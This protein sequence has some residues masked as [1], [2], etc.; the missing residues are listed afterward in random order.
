MKL[1]SRN[2]FLSILFIVSLNNFSRAQ[3]IRFAV[4]VIVSPDVPKT[5]SL[6]M[7]GNQRAFGNWFDF[8]KGKM[9]KQDDTTWTFTG[10]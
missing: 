8:S 10:Q 7:M 6:V 3:N 1:S 5:D 2:L 4:K 9:K